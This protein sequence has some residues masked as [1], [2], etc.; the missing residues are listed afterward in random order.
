MGGVNRTI[1]KVTFGAKGAVS[2]NEAA[3]G[4]I[5]LKKGAKISLA[6]DEEDPDNWYFFL[7][8]EHGFEVRDVK[9][10]YWLFQHTHLVRQFMEGKGLE[11]GKS[12]KG[13]IAGQP[14]VIKGDK[15]N[16]QY[17]GILIRPSV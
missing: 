15:A 16:T 12:A 7:D 5:G 4:L 1:A 11:V 8:K 2:F 10:K 9:G 17:W 13:I 6:Q 14:T 3:A